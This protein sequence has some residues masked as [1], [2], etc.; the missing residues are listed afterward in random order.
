MA[1]T[2]PFSGGNS[3]P[4]GGNGPYSRTATPRSVPNTPSSFPRVGYGPRP[5]PPSPAPPATPVTPP[6]SPANP[7]PSAPVPPTS[8]APAA[9]SPPASPPAAGPAAA[10][11]GGAGGGFGLLPLVVGA[12]AGAIVFLWG[13][14]PAGE[15]PRPA[16]PPKE[17]EPPIIPFTGG[18]S[19]VF[20]KVEVQ[21]TAIKI[22]TDPIYNH[23]PPSITGTQIVYPMGPIRGLTSRNHTAPEGKYTNHIVLL[24]TKPP[25]TDPNNDRWDEIA[26]T[27]PE[28]TFRSFAIT[29]IT[30]QDGQP[31]TGGDPPPINQPIN[32]PP[33][34]TLQ[35]PT[36]PPFVGENP[37]PQPVTPQQQGRVSSPT[38]AAAS[39]TIP[40]TNTPNQ[41][42]EV[43]PLAR[44][45]PPAVNPTPTA[46]ET[47]TPPQRTPTLYGPS[48]GT[49]TTRTTSPFGA[50]NAL[51][52][53]TPT[54]PAPA[55][56]ISTP[57]TPNPSG[58]PVPA[59]PQSPQPQTPTTPTDEPEPT[60]LERIITALQN[61]INAA[62]LLVGINQIAQGILQQTNP[63]NIRDAARQG[64]CD[65]FNPGGCNADIRQN[66]Q[67][68]ANGTNELLNRLS[69]INQTLIPL[70]WGTT[71][72]INNK[73]G[74]QMPGGISGFLQT[75][76]R[77]TRLDK[78][79]NALTLITTLHNAAMLSRNLGQTLGELTSQALATIGI[80]DEND[81][82]IDINAEIGKQ[83][84]SL[85]STILGADTW[86]GTKLA[87]NKANAIIS[88]ANQI[89]W[90]VRSISDSAREVTEWIAN[91]TGKIGNALKRFRVVGENAYPHMAENVNHQ[92]TWML[93]IQRYREGVDSLDDAASSLQ[94]VL[95]EVQNI[96]SE[97]KELKEQKERFDKAIQD[98]EPK[99]IPDNKPVKEKADLSKT[100]SISPATTA[101]VFRGEGESTSA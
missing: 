49:G 99:A 69:A 5:G 74:A 43:Q 47:G 30:R 44:P 53:T 25:D 11:A 17:I 33:G 19:P 50:T 87:W 41:P 90:T 22:T 9:A 57:F 98:A 13:H 3:R 60:E 10:A 82:P 72:T 86:A 35:S 73:L 66:S 29:R 65:S 24:S 67:N 31:D 91:N 76:F 51:P 92:N 20:Y 48:A 54:A 38:P 46:P 88:S 23:L 45:A 18:Q 37:P 63:Q 61:A 32:S 71:Q 83:V 52:T 80:K 7:A 4:S 96:Q 36:P 64:T 75:A 56:P 26:G 94:G 70:I 27:S 100:V 78:I 14:E 97:A 2:S 34:Q 28:Y 89:I 21:Y 1:N 62:P 77:A 39:P 12:A 55:P 79:I 84:N 8:P 95:G 42:Q 85:M 15:V 59:T 58:D 16:E 6:V 93:K 40:Q 81:S 101:D 68:A